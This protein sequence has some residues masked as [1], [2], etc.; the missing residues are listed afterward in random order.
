M[1]STGR[2]LLF[3]SAT[4]LLEDA[5]AGHLGKTGYAETL[6]IPGKE[7]FDIIGSYTELSVD[8]GILASA[9]AMRIAS[10]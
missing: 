8:Q 7:F 3:R 5:L 6:L 10:L 2:F 1:E 4:A 9:R